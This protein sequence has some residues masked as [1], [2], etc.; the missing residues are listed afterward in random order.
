MS[1][2]D[3]RNVFLGRQLIL[4]R[5][6]QSFAYALSF[7][8]AG[9]D[10]ECSGVGGEALAMIV[11]QAFSEL[12]LA[13]ALGTYEGFVT[14]APG[15]LSSDRID[16]LPKSTVVLEIP[17]ATPQT[18][19]VI[20]HCERIRRAGYVLAAHARP[21]A[22]DIDGR[23][24]LKIAEFIKVDVSRAKPD[25]L[26]QLVPALKSLR[27]TLLAEK[28]E[29]D[30][31]RHLCHDLGFDLFQGNY[32]AQPA[33][34]GSR[35]LQGSEAALLRLLGLIG[36]NADTVEIE[37]AFKQEPALTISLLR[38]T[39]SAGS[40]LTIR[41]TSLHHAIILL[42][43]RQLLRWLQLLLYSGGS[44]SSSA[45]NP[46]MQLAATRGRLMELLVDHTAEVRGCG[47]DLVDQAFMV[48]ILSLL[49]AI[50]GDESDEIL[51]RMPLA[52]PVI[53]ALV[54]RAGVL[55]NLLALVEA[56]EEEIPDKATAILRGLPGIDAA[57]ANACL[58][59]ALGWAN[60]LAR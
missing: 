8:P 40:G 10:E 54:R 34:T 12:P 31:R 22:P 30:A 43:R 59:Q 56:A 4:D 42:G 50:L 57:Y 29:N 6:Q 55:G 27:K 26:K 17:D 20:A 39:N 15:M 58:V 60:N 45:T 33:E 47:R 49:P 35:Q 1:N 5:Q 28:V 13:E 52:E 11:A 21:E 7:H 48:G 9:I 41:I 2:I 3:L 25:S 36:Q 32:F 16:A 23:P 19:E 46:L 44:S 38:L 37:A 24:L 18:P 14:V 51:A 53:D